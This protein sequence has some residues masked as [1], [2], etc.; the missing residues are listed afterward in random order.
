MHKEEQR[1]SKT[2]LKMKM[3][4]KRLPLLNTKTQDKARVIKATVLLADRQSDQR[5]EIAWNRT[6]QKRNIKIWPRGQGTSLGKREAA[7]W[8]KIGYLYGKR[9]EH[10]SS[11]YK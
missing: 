11:L 8:Q 9:N 1:L 6:M 3:K 2:L 4:E 7:Q 5:N 10:G